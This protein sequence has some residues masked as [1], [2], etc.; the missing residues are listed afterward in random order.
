MFFA[1]TG[2][3][4]RIE[5]E[6]VALLAGAIE[7]VLR[8]GGAS[9]AMIRPIA[10]G[11]ALFAVGGSPLNKVAGLGFGG[12]L[13]EADLDGIER[14]YA[15]RGAA[16]HVELSTLADPSIGALLTSRGYRL[17]GFEN[18]LGLDLTADVPSP[19]ATIRS[20]DVSV[21]LS[22]DFETWLDTVVT[23]FASPD[24]AGVPAHE[25]FPR[26][27]LETVMRDMAGAAGL[28]RFIAK[29]GDEVAGGASMR[30][31]N[32]VAQMCGAATLPSLRRRGVQAALLA[33]RLAE[34]SAAGC[35]VAVVTTQPGSISQK[36]VQRKGFELLYSR[37]VLVLTPSA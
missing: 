27:I 35:D 30:I 36:N 21:E 11:A 14:E 16:V 33:H 25:S 9:D 15:A 19:G 20:A 26:E 13:V 17:V 7:A 34:A 37:A 8:Q 32:G 23:G 6:E 5:R 24:L 1:S 2:L 31:G 3:A 29:L 10:G 22:G 28:V 4:A 18:V 12:P